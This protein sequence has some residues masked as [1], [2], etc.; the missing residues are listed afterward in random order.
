MGST[1]RDQLLVRAGVVTDAREPVRQAAVF[2][3]VLSGRALPAPARSSAPFPQ[4]VCPS[5]VIAMRIP[6]FEDL[7]P[8]PSSR[9]LGR[10]DGRGPPCP[11]GQA[12]NL[13]P[14]AADGARKSVL[15]AALYTTRPHPA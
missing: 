6:I 3:Q 14:T 12:A 13:G 15:Q 8:D 1:H 10:L 2:P 4:L 5:L 7:G 11:D 9:T